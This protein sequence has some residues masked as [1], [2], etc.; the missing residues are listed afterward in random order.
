MKTKI[1]ILIAL[2]ANTVCSLAQESAQS[3]DTKKYAQPVEHP[4]VYSPQVEAMMRYDNSSVNLNTGTV[5][6]TVPLVEFD[7]PDFDLNVSITYSSDGFKPLQPDNF[8]GMGWRL[9]CGGVITREVH[10][11]PD[12]FTN[13][14][15]DGGFVG[16]YEIPNLQGFMMGTPADASFMDK[17][18]NPG[19]LEGEFQQAY[20]EKGTRKIVV[21]KGGNTEMSP[22]LYR[23]SFGSHSGHFMYDLDGTLKVVSDGGGQYLVEFHGDAIHIITDDGYRYVFGG[24]YQALEYT[25]L[26]WKDFSDGHASVDIYIMSNREHKREITAYHLT[27]V[28]APNGRE[29]NYVYES[30]P[31]QILENEPVKMINNTLNNTTPYLEE[32]KKFYQVIPSMKGEHIDSDLE[33]CTI[34]YTVNKVAL[35]RTVYVDDKSIKFSYGNYS[36]PYFCLPRQ[37]AWSNYQFVSGCGARL[38]SIKATNGISK[39]TETVNLGY[40]ENYGRLLLKEIQH[41]TT[42]T[43][44][45]DYYSSRTFDKSLTIDI[46]KWGFWSGAGANTSIKQLADTDRLNQI[47]PVTGEFY[48]VPNDTNRE[49]TGTEYDVFMLQKVTYPTGGNMTYEYEPHTYSCFFHKPS[50]S[51]EGKVDGVNSFSKLAGGARICKETFVDKISPKNRIKR[52]I[53]DREDGRSNG[54]LRTEGENYLKPYPIS[55]YGSEKV[56]SLK[57][58]SVCYQTECEKIVRNNSM[59]GYI[60]YSQILEYDYEGSDSDTLDSSMP[61]KATE[62]IVDTDMLPYSSVISF[63]SDTVS[64]MNYYKLLGEY[65][66]L[67]N[68]YAVMPDYSKTVGKIRSESFYAQDHRLQMKKEYAY[69]TTL[70]GTARYVNGYPAVSG[71]KVGCYSQLAQIPLYHHLL[72]EVKTTEYD[73]EGRAHVTTVSDEYDSQGYKTA[74]VTTDSEGRVL[75]TTYEYPD[76]RPS[77]SNVKMSMLNIISPV[78]AETVTTDSSEVIYQRRNDYKII[79]RYDL[80][81]PADT[82]RELTVG[83]FPVLAA[84]YDTYG[85]GEPQK[86]IEYLSFDQ[87][88]NPL[89]LRS[90][91]RDYVYVWGRAGQD[92]LAVI[93]NATEEE[94][95]E[96]LDVE[97]LNVISVQ[98][99]PSND[100]GTVIRN[101]LPNSLVT[102]YTYLPGV[103]V[104]SQT[105]PDGQT[106]YYEYDDRGR[107]SYIY[108]M[109]GDVKSIIEKYD[110]N[111]VNE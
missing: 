63:V 23:F 16:C 43:F 42:G 15:T 76:D 106:T 92:I 86:Q 6:L 41:S 96:A 98:Y 37:H 45:F 74:S 111:L 104:A 70:L 89:W 62:Y 34:S 36:S 67:Y 109:D 94:V 83:D 90:H 100:V 53:Y 47:D 4:S 77:V 97:G 91:G 40:Q 24:D 25:A 107:L 11:I 28:V 68:Y 3:D 8:V 39:F 12:E 20:I 79:N 29:L 71:S 44:S 95:A 10:G 56:D 2:L 65:G 102:S 84:V 58:V 27:K 60:S 110:Y 17:I 30:M 48:R 38:N 66:F 49:P 78:I 88:G 31:S 75:K 80:T 46:D 64:T 19:N 85:D 14:H 73:S 57:P 93:R 87:Y 33:T 21:R 22:D 103:G 52:Y 105:T 72:T 18:V 9:N 1:F 13:I 82:C 55:E 81:A 35:L 32:Y 99:E 61:H 5:S 108:R 50:F 26:S 7:D 59:G 51:Y 69:T 54:F 101:A